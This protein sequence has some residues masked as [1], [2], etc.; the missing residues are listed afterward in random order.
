MK[1]LMSA[2]LLALVAV[3]LVSLLLPGIPGTW[4]RAEPYLAVREGK[5][6]LVCHVNP[7][8]GGKRTEF[9][10]IYAQTMLSAKFVRPASPALPAA[11]KD[12]AGDFDGIGEADRSAPAA[13]FDSGPSNFWNGEISDQLSI[14]G[15]V[16]SRVHYSSVP[17]DP[18]QFS[19]RFDE[20]I[21]YAEFV[22]IPD[23]LLFY[24]D[25]KAAPSLLNREAWVLLRGASGNGYLKAGKMFLPYGFRLE[26]DNAFIRQFPKARSI[27][28]HMP[29]PF[30]VAAVRSAPPLGS[31]LNARSSRTVE[32]HRIQ[33]V[34]YS[35]LLNGSS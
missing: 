31:E 3:A 29:Y 6:C 8:G 26:D 33:E 13:T 14:G 15:D 12:T 28:L 10:N 1:R 9:G 34:R 19:L 25:E 4:M 21:L 2:V 20:A 17:N 11:S 7:S 22:I 16:R 32:Q 30:V 18:D 24:L 5:K 35:Q 27:F 23:R